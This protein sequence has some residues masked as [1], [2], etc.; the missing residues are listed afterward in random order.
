MMM[1]QRPAMGGAATRSRVYGLVYGLLGGAAVIAF[2]AIVT[3]RLT[4]GASSKP[5]GIAGCGSASGTAA[6]HTLL[7]VNATSPGQLKAATAKFGQL[8]IIRVYYTGLPDPHAWTTGAPALNHSAVVLSF[9]SPP[10]KIL[11]GADDAAL[12]DFFET[13]PARYP[14]YYSYYHEPEPAI[15]SGAFTLAQYKAAWTHIVAIARKAHNR[16]LESTLILMS[17]DLNPASG[18][19]WRD[20]LPAGHIIGNL[21]WDAYPAGTVHDSDPQPTPPAQ[22]MGEAEAAS[23]SAGLPFGFA[24]FAL[25]TATGRPQWLTD[26]A[27][28]LRRTGASFGVLFD[29][30]GYPWMQL[31]DS[32]SIRSWRAAIAMQHGNHA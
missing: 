11:S 32:A 27:S 4:G 23:R 26:V 6:G 14:I 2:A 7:G 22:F 21:T 17:W 12:T 20:Y 15:E 28:Y 19:N 1:Q 8:P 13:A 29:S 30:S 16:C 5:A 31:R 3:L 24:E 9:R 10:A 25:G 18:V